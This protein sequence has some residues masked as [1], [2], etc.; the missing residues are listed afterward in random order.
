VRLQFDD[1][2]S[3][4]ETGNP[5]SIILKAKCETVLKVPMKSKDLKVGL[6]SKTELLP[7]V[8]MAE[9]LSVVRE[10]G[11]LTSILN[12]N[13][14]VSLS[15]PL[16]NLEE[17]NIEYNAIEVDIFLV[18]GAVTR[19][20]RLPELRQRIRTDHLNDQKRRAIMSIC[21]YYNDTF[22][23]PG[24]N[25]TTTTAIEHAIPTPGIDPCRGIA[26]RNYQI[27]EALKD[28]LQSIVNQMLRDK[29][30][31]HSSSS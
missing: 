22:R 19:E 14:D 5:I 18:Q 8:C 9:T 13:E 11:C 16:V 7:G 4:D 23:L 26:S 20:D 30:I 25:V 6:I 12:M 31:R 15:L 17:C 2:V 24:D 1:K 21:E 29:I 3:T 10:G 27:P 28:E